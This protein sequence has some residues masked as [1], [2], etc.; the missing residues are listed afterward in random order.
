MLATAVAVLATAPGALAAAIGTGGCGERGGEGGLGAGLGA[1]PWHR[2][3]SGRARRGARRRPLRRRRL[4]V[5]HRG[6][7]RRTAVRRQLVKPRIPASNQKL[8]VTA[9]LLAE[10]R[11]AAR[12]PD[13]RLRA[14]GGLDGRRDSV[15]AGDLVIVGDGDPPSTRP[16]RRAHDQPATRVS[17]SPATSPPPGSSGSRAGSSPTPRSSTASAGPAL[18]EPALRALVQQRLR[19]RLCPLARAGRRQGPEERPAQAGRSGPRA[20]W[21]REP[22]GRGA[23]LRAARLGR[24]ADGGEAD[25]GDQRALE[26][27]LRGDAAQAA[28]GDEQR[29]GHPQAGQQQ[30]R[31]VRALGRRRPRRRR[32]LGPVAPQPGLAPTRRPAAGRDGARRA[33]LDRVHRLAAGRRPRGRRRRP[34]ARHRRRGQ[35]R[36]PRPGPS[37]ASPR[38]PATARPAATRSR[39]RP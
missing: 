22:P 2:R 23:S 16:L 19:R 3:A 5:R 1:R 14:R 25:R 8:F 31:R 29:E 15:V 4:G 34:H 26:Q 17:S 37:P 18:P 38:S 27:L 10:L 9:A 6:L 7:R 21:T 33:E 20:G 12:L 28:R 32:R 30:G 11:T 39:S 35:L 36:E 24:L 13:P